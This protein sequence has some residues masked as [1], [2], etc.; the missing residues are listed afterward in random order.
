MLSTPVL[1]LDLARL[2]KIR[3]ASIQSVKGF[4]PNHLNISAVVSKKRPRSSS[5]GECDS[6]ACSSSSATN[7]PTA[8][9]PTDVSDLSPSEYL[10]TIF[11]ANGFSDLE[12]IAK[13]CEP[14]FLPVTTAMMEA[15][16]TEILNAVRSNNLEQAQ[17]LYRA[18]GFQHGCNAC[19]RFGESILHIACRRG[20]LGMVRFFVEEVGLDVTAI[21]DDY[22]RTPLH[23]AFWTSTASYE[24]VDFL[25]R[26]PHVPDLLLCKDK[27]GFTPLDY[28]RGEDRGR[29]LDFLSERSAIL[30]PYQAEKTSSSESPCKR[31]RVVA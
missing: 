23:D 24:V 15:Y 3:N 22:H 5:N 21:R 25:L 1:T 28:S 17:A 6:S 31:M 29:W 20:N 8:A 30:R 14:R 9:L 13:N 26:Q 27:R 16:H 12:S 4:S 19:N 10:K 2:A 7:T 11:R 18:G